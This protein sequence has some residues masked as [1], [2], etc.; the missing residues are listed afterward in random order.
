MPNPP[1]WLTMLI[2]D[3]ESEIRRLESQ[4]HGSNQA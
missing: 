4:Q 3:T 1:E 2:G